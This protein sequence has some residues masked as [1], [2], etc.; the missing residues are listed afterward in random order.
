[1]K[2]KLVATILG[3]AASAAMSYG[4][5][6]IAMTSYLYNGGSPLYSGIQFS[7]GP[8]AGQYVGAEFTAQLMYQFGTMTSYA[9]AGGNSLVGIYP[10]AADGGSPTTDGAGIFINGSGNSGAYA[11]VPGYSAGAVSFEI[12][13]TGTTGGVTYS[14]TSAPF[15]IPSLQTSALAAAGDI[16]NVTGGVVTGFAPMSVIPVP[17]PTTFALVGLAAS[18]MLVLRRRR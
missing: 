4:Q 12:V 15:S 8:H 6:Y 18:A 13:A 17:E 14:G 11:I 10:G 1:M 7:S 3:I 2:R 16:L 5:G 9:A